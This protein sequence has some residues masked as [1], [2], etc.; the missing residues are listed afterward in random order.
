MNI[1]TRVSS[2]YRPH[3]GSIVGALVL[4]MLAIGFNILKP[5]PLKYVVDG[6]LIESGRLP[7][8]LPVDT[9]GGALLSAAAAFV[10]IHVVWGILHMLSTYWLI[11]I[12]LR[13]MVRLRAE[14]FEKLHALSLKFHNGHNSSD[15]VYRVVYD[16]QSIQTFFNQ[17]FATIVGSGLTLIGML[18]VMWQMNVLLTLLSLSV[19]PFL[20]LTLWFFAKR[21]RQRS[22]EVQT[23]ESTVLRLVNDSLRNLKLIRLMNRHVQEK[24]FFDRSCQE[25]LLANRALNRTNL[26]STLAVGVI[27]TCGGAIL[28]YFGSGQVVADSAFTV[29]DLL[30]FLAYLA[31]FYQPLEQLT[32][33]TW[34]VE[35][36]AAHAERVFEV[37]DYEQ[38]KGQQKCQPDLPG[39]RGNLEVNDV[40]FSYET[41]KPV[42]SDI[43]FAVRPGETVAFVGGTGAGKTTLLSLI[44]RLYEIESGQVTIDGHDISQYSRYSLREQISMVLQE[45]LLID[46]TVLENLCYA[47]P[48]A[49]GDQC[50]NALRAAQAAE[51]VESLPDQLDTQIG[52]QGVRLSG[53]QRQRIGIA[54]AILRDTPVLLLDEPTS[55]LDLKTEADL[56]EAFR[57]VT[58]KPATLIVTHRLHTIHHCDRIYVLNQGRIM[59]SGSG[60]ELLSRKGLYHALYNA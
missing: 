41:G 27:I 19:V 54:R 51:Y 49:T 10:I 38:G 30:V 25:S 5:W 44:P 15:L 2:Y 60:P 45:T 29:G 21:V 36:A 6:L 42:L 23:R 58:A 55:S 13:A 14:C 59:E 20:L 17:G 48:A 35:G 31:M 9:F 46:G 24:H 16:A 1:Y 39:I 28:L 52:E 50:W 33:T 8:W 3:L 22:S 32:Y 53:G 47:R 4:M 57:A 37:L 56:M 40:S 34:A 7:W 12:G 43:S 26:V 18:I 11:E